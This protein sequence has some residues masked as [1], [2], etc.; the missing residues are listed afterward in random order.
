MNKTK[1]YIII[2]L[3]G[4][5]IGCLQTA[6]TI[7]GKVSDSAGNAAGAGIV[8]YVTQNH[9]AATTDASGTYSI[10]NV[11]VGSYT[12]V[13]ASGVYTSSSTAVTLADSM[14]SCAP[15]QVTTDIRF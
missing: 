15:L 5:S 7:T 12:V 3:L 1:L 11:P 13:A 2:L 10:S 4:V 6:G 9:F 14:T 8:V